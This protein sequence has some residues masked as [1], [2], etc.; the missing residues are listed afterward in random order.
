MD[1]HGYKNTKAFVPVAWNRYRI[2]IKYPLQHWLLWHL[3]YFN[4]ILY[5]IK[6]FLSLWKRQVLSPWRSIAIYCFSTRLGSRMS[7]CC[8][9]S[10]RTCT[11]TQSYWPSCLMNKN[12]SSL[13]RWERYVNITI[14][15]ANTPPP[16]APPH[17]RSYRTC[18]G[19]QSSWRSYLTNK[20]SSSLSKWERYAITPNS[21]NTPP[22]RPTPP[23]IVQDMYVDPELLAELS[24]EQ[25]QLLFVKMR[26]VCYNH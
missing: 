10:C 24:D 9:R 8:S 2:N 15:S 20:N 4:E 17:P 26:E 11:W 25:K 19:T 3:K 13:S 6:W 1:G 14:N 18:T 22:P 23:Q 12:S 16:P 21:A 7:R 5:K